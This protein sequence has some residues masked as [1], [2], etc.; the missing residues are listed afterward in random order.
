MKGFPT[1]SK[2]FKPPGKS[3]FGSNS[4]LHEFGVELNKME[5][6]KIAV[7]FPVERSLGRDN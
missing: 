6:H 7:N 3:C 5:P 2:D 4:T 1:C